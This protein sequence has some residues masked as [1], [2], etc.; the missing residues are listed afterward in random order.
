MPAFSNC[1]SSDTAC[2]ARLEVKVRSYIKQALAVWYMA[3][4]TMELDTVPIEGKVYYI[5]GRC[6]S[7]VFFVEN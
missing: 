5:A 3:I 7:L 4:L 2:S 1:L 6:I